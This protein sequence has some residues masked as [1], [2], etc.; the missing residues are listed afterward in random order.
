M[1]MFLISIYAGAIIGLLWTI[2]KKLIDINEYLY[3]L[4]IKKDI[5]GERK[6]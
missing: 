4:L 6:E 5:H 3:L 1:D 2:V